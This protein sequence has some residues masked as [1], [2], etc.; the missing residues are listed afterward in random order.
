M[1]RTAKY[2]LNLQTFPSIRL[3]GFSRQSLRSV[4]EFIMGL[5]VIYRLVHEFS[6]IYIYI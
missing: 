3:D 6:F 5:Q 2:Q 1:Y 4:D